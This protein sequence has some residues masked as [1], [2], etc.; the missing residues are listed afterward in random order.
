[1]RL[2]H[3]QEEIL[4]LT[5]PMIESLRALVEHE[6]PSRDKGALD[7][8]AAI[9]AERFRAIDCD[10]RTV[11][12]PLGG[13]HLVVRFDPEGSTAKPALVLAHF[14]TVWP[15]GTLDRMPFRV[16]GDLASG[17]GIYDMK[18]S[19]VQAEFALKAIRASGRA[20][21]RP[22]ELLLTSDEE[23]GSTTSRSLIEERAREAAHVLVLE[24]ALPD[25][26][27]K[28]ARKGV[29]I[30]IV[31]IEGR[32]AHSGVEPE[33]G[34][35]AIQELAH[36]I[37]RIHDLG[38]PEFQT[39]L[40]VGVVS[41]GTTSNTV[42]ASATARVDVRVTIPEEEHRLESAMVGLQPVLPGAKI[43]VRGGFNRPPMVRTPAVVRLYEEVRA[44]GQRLG[45]DL[46]EGSTG[47]GSDGNFTAALG[48]PTLDGLGVRGS[49]AHAAHEQIAV[50]SLPERTALLA[51]VLLHV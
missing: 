42:A 28:T 5:G 51:A 7:G 33:K 11:P 45:L 31:E 23:I 30:Y 12:N 1:M 37:L 17:P 38:N 32:A 19:L 21:R 36:Q 2:E 9:L 50:S 10:V 25:G 47:G 3:L 27:L 41:G 46:G 13:D 4:G 49:G 26:S 40:N 20:P 48:I 43:H 16:E 18:A 14:D 15:R 34:I 24:P 39:T 29:G 44:V 6:S 8:L 35:S 22:I